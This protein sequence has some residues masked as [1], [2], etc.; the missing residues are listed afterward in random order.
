M[1]EEFQEKTEQPTARK[2]QRARQQGTVPQSVELGTA[3]VLITGTVALL[4][5][6][7]GIVDQICWCFRAI[8]G[9]L[10]AITLTTQNIP[11][12]FKLGGWFVVKLLAPFM[13]MVALVGLAANVLQ[14]GVTFTTKPV[15]PQFN[16]LN[17][18]QG[19]K[20]VFSLR[21]LV[22]AA[23]GILKL[24]IVGWIGYLTIKA[25]I[26]GLLPL[27]DQQVGQIIAAIA[28]VALKL[29]LRVALV[30]LLLGLLD[31]K[32]Q[33]WKH[34]QDLKMTK[35]E[36]KDEH[37]QTEGDPKIKAHLRR[38]QYRTSL[39]RMIKKLPEADVVVSNPV[40]VAVALKYDAEVMSAP[41]VIAKGARKLAERIKRIA[42]ENDIPIVEEPELARA[43]YRTVE[44]GWEIPY[45]LFQAVAEVLALVYRLKEAA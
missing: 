31:L 44:V 39:N 43:L 20:R 3:V 11:G 38:I 45:E 10:S 25:E 16:R 14:V 12:Y 18:V 13:L 6:G 36:V 34:I 24:I 28:A 15:T 41:K 7:N 26:P 33:R 5:F 32:F 22:E 27:M 23:K 37:K 17:P 9:E 42:E 30:I 1:P 40:H 8:Y 19:L 29:C 21:G 2:K 4:I 35:Q